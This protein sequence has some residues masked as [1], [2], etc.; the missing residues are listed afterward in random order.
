MGPERRIS[1]FLIDLSENSELLRVYDEDAQ[2]AMTEYGLDAAQQEIILSADLGR[3]RAAVQAEN[4]DQD[5]FVA[6][7]WR[8]VH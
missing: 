8:P 3:V 7:Y 5:V 6:L 4:P 1:D 2:K